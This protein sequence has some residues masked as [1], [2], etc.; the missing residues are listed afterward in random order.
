MA[1]GRAGKRKRWC[2]KGPANGAVTIFK[3]FY[4]TAWETSCRG[5]S[6]GYGET[7]VGRGGSILGVLYSGGN[8]SAGLVIRALPSVA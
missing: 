3:A 6:W 7:L 4:H 5:R 2:L 8:R 1:G